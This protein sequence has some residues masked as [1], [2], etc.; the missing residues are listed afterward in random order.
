MCEELINLGIIVSPK[1]PL[2]TRDIE[3]FAFNNDQLYEIMKHLS[4]YQLRKLCISNKE[5]HNSCRNNKLIQDLI[6]S[7]QQNI[8]LRTNN[9][10]KAQNRRNQE[11]IDQALIDASRDGDVDVVDRLLKLGANQNYYTNYTDNST[12]NLSI[13]LSSRNGHFEVVNRLLED[14]KTDPSVD[15]NAPLAYAVSNGYEGIIDRL[16]ADPRINLK[17]S[18]SNHWVLDAAIKKGDLELV[19][20]LLDDPRID[21]SRH[22]DIAIKR[23]SE[24]GYYGLVKRLLAD[25]RVNPN[26]YSHESPLAE[27]IKHGH[28][29]IVDLLLSDQRVDPSNYHNHAL[30]LASEK[31]DLELVNRL[32]QNSKVS[33]NEDYGFSTPALTEAIENGHVEIA[34]RILDD[35]R[36]DPS[37]DNNS[38]LLK[39]S[40]KGYCKLVDRLLTDSR[41]KFDKSLS[42]RLLLSKNPEVVQRLLQED[43]IDPSINNNSAIKRASEYGYP[44]TVAMLLQDSRVDPSVSD[45]YAIQWA[46]RNGHLEVVNLLLKDRRVDS[47][48]SKNLPLRWAAKYEQYHIVKRLLDEPKVWNYL[49]ADQRTMYK[50]MIQTAINSEI[51]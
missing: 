48:V 50:K 22:F 5:I 42:P 11:N 21:P 9:Y 25:A 29:D 20:R 23:A 30:R 41:L 4:Y 49:Y 38:A 6:H 27:A 12:K 8:T 28:K 51:K 16:L 35:P 39:A 24:L 1:A 46:A 10:I 44:A 3:P 32:L 43:R 45:N 18:D 47:T 19:N 34:N 26:E 33:P 14:P 2:T 13:Q 31:G 40:E 37:A 7:K 36:T 17:Y 15:N